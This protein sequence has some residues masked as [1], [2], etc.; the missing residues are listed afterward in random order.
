MASIIRQDI[1]TK[2]WTIFSE[3]RASRP[4]Y[5]REK[6]YKKKLKRYEPGCPFCRGNEDQTPKEVLSISNGKD[7]SVRVVKNKF[8]AVRHSEDTGMLFHGH[9]HTEG[10]NLSIDGVGEHE[11]IIESPWHDDNLA[12]MESARVEK[13]LSAYRRRFIDVSRN[14]GNQL[15]VIFKNHGCRA[16]TSLDHPHSQLVATPFV[17]G[18]IRNKM[19]ESQRYYDD[20]GRCV[21]CDIIDYEMKSK[22]RLVHVNDK[23]IAITPFASIVPYNIIIYPKKHQSCFA[24][25]DE[26]DLADLASVLQ[27]V[28]NKL[29]YLLNDPDYNF[30]IDSSP[31]DQSGN[32]HHHWHIE[33]IPRLS[34]RAGFEI[35]SGININ[36]ILPETCAKNLR[37]RKMD[38]RAYF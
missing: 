31:I 4:N 29:Y 16:G 24:E 28:L 22:E 7:W 11:V 3:E 32:R 5:N 34:T 21:F 38:Q 10:P 12:K 36:T 25:I 35:G 27:L 20:Y 18:Y 26:V 1:S 13:V 2:N 6:E 17:P 19:F 8:P 33:I 14:P 30:V 9:R 23:Y 15:V 37:D